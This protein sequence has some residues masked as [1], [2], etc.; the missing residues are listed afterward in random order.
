MPKLLI[1]I[2]H[3]DA[4]MRRNLD[5]RTDAEANRIRRYLGMDDLSRKDKGPIREL[6]DNIVKLEQF[7]DFDI[8]QIPEIVPA[9]ASFDLFNFPPDHPARSKSDTY[10]V[11]EKNILRASQ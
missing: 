11:D 4:E 2:H 8:I 10:Y 3:S 7:K 6:V 1:N 9:D 5:S